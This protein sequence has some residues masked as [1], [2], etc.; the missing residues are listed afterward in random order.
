MSLPS[1]V[2]VFTIFWPWPLAYASA[3]A[4]DA[5]PA[6]SQ[7][8]SGRQGRGEKGLA[9]AATVTQRREAWPPLNWICVPP[10]THTHCGD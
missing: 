10:S 1:M 2:D 6:E 8:R 9:K 7:K 5:A 3:R 4:R